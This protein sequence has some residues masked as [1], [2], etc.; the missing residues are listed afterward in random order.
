MRGTRPAVFLP[1]LA[2]L[3]ALGCPASGPPAV[4]EGDIVFQTSRS[5]QSLAIQ[6]ATHSVYSHVGL[7]TFR[8]GK[9]LVL[10]AEAT[11]RLTPLSE[12]L[13][14]GE[15]GHYVVK[16]LIDA[17]QVLD[18]ASLV[19]LKKQ[20]RRFEGAPYDSTF[21]WSD[22][23]LYAPELVWKVY[24]RALGIRLGEPQQLRDFDLAV[25]EVQAKLA[26]RFGAQVP[27]DEPV[28]SPQRLFDSARLATVTER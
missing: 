18:T 5:P 13:E 10:E 17:R 16:R 23:R 1:L 11:V 4:E 2:A 8:D 19:E 3:L 20:M 28:I 9:P 26:Q 22:E 25:P 27:L 14:R 15:G 6:K 24:E 7:V 21:E 12:W